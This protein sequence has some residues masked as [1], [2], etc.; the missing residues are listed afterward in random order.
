MID[1]EHKE[2]LIAT[3]QKEVLCKSCEEDTRSASTCKC[4]CNITLEQKQTLTDIFR[5]AY[6]TQREPTT[7]R[8]VRL[9]HHILATNWDL[10]EK[11]ARVLQ[12]SLKEYSQELNLEVTQAYRANIQSY[13]DEF[14]GVIVTEGHDDSFLLDINVDSVKALFLHKDVEYSRDELLSITLEQNE[15]RLLRRF[16]RR[17]AKRSWAPSAKEFRSHYRAQLREQIRNVRLDTV[18]DLFAIMQ[19]WGCFVPAATVNQYLTFYHIPSKSLAEGQ[20]R[21]RFCLDKERVK[22]SSSLLPKR[23]VNN[24]IKARFRSFSAEFDEFLAEQEREARE[25]KERREAKKEQRESLK[26]EAARL[27]EEAKQRK[28]KLKSGVEFLTQER[29]MERSVKGDHRNPYI[30][31]LPTKQDFAVLDGM[32]KL[33]MDRKADKEE[34]ANAVLSPQAFLLKERVFWAVVAARWEVDLDQALWKRTL[35]KVGLTF[36]TSGQIT[37]EEV[38]KIR[39]AVAKWR[40]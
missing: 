13:D 36:K 5:N 29:R 6:V 30:D 37:Y 14:P 19:K 2:H 24:E 8:Q 15:P 7:S 33:M 21:L 35:S 26:A 22:N 3:Q 20:K 38:V 11:K 32:L 34:V 1:T 18:E 27:K 12:A 40:E 28:A 10:V 4:K 31:V 25:K 17:V 16:Q 9:V 39:E 23:K